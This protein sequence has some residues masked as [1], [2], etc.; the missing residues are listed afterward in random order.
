VESRLHWWRLKVWQGTPPLWL[1]WGWL[2]AAVLVTAINL[3]AFMRTTPVETDLLALLPATER[4]PVA[5]MAAR[6][7]GAVAG[8]RALF[9]IGGGSQS[10]VRKGAIRFANALHSD[11]VKQIFVRHDSLNPAVLTDSYAAYRHQLLTREVQSVLSNDS[12]FEHAIDQRLVRWYGP[13]SLLP[14]DLD[15]FGFITDWLGALPYGQFRL[16]PVDGWLEIRDQG[17][18]WVMVSVELAGSAFDASIQTDFATALERA[19]HA[20]ESDGGEWKLLRVGAIFYAMEARLNSEQELRLIGIG[21]LFGIITLLLFVYRSLSPLLLGLLSIGVGISSAIFITTTLFGKI[22][23][24]TLVFGASL[25]GEAIDYGIQFFAARMSAGC[26]WQVKSGIPSVRP[27]LLIALLTSV[28]GYTAI[29]ITPFP[30]MHQM[31]VFAITGLIAAW[32]TANL[33]IPRWLQ[34]PQRHASHHLQL[35]PQHWLDLWHSYL[36]RSRLW[37]LMAVLILLSI[38]GILS[39]TINDDIR[40]LIDRP[41]HLVGQEHQIR[42]LTGLEAGTRFFLI[43]AGDQ[44]QLLRREEKLR[45]AAAAEGVELFGLSRFVP[46]CGRQLEN[47][48]LMRQRSVAMLSRL[49]QFGFSEGSLA[50]WSRGLEEEAE[51]LRLDEWLDSPLSMVARHLWLG[52]S[53]GEVAMV[54]QPLNL[55]DGTDL[56]SLAAGIE[57]V[58]LIDKPGAVSQLFAEYRHHTG[59]A[60]VAATLLILLVMAVRYGY[61]QALLVILPTVAAQL[62][63]LAVLGYAGIEVTLFN[64]LALLLILG[65]GVNYTIFLLEGEMVE[66]KRRPAILLGVSLSAAT[67]LLSFGLL[68]F[69]SMPVLASFGTTLATG[70]AVSI[71]LA[72]SVTLIS[73]HG[74]SA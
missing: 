74:R 18:N 8:E 41:D 47:L 20:L 40:L 36:T 37:L 19:Q 14:M 69:S 26:N 2:T 60:I 73:G 66:V 65:V 25:I 32:W 43:E 35:L 67:T 71:L 23:L 57:G 64:L 49:E 68:S 22:H 58:N 12:H 17:V 51:C 44:E 53:A 1:L 16:Q 50:V 15:P 46:S 45:Q 27:A 54:A 56:K 39:I 63:T 24:M 70:V 13:G 34:R 7:L 4:N 10:A 5:E 62:L 28:V 59:W 3:D 9:L 72:P 48:K 6:R 52:E 42:T 11:P 38:P 21:T 61:R 55:P 31:A 29:G 30:A 33:V